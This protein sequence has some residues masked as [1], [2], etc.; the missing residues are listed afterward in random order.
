MRSTNVSLPSP[1]TLFTMKWIVCHSWV[2]LALVAIGCTGSP[3]AQFKDDPLYETYSKII[4]QY[5][6]H[7]LAG[8]NRIITNL[9]QAK[10]DGTIEANVFSA[11]KKK[12]VSRHVNLLTTKIKEFCQTDSTNY[13][14]PKAI[15]GFEKE[16]IMFRELS[17]SNIGKAESLVK[18]YKTACMAFGDIY[19]LTR[20]S[21]FSKSRY[22]KYTQL[23]KAYAY[24][25][26]PFRYNESLKEKITQYLNS[27]NQHKTSHENFDLLDDKD[28][29]DIDC[30]TE[31]DCY[32]SVNLYYSHK[33]KIRRVNVWLKQY[34]EYGMQFGTY[35]T[36]RLLKELKSLESVKGKSFVE[37]K[38]R[39]IAK[40]QAVLDTL[41]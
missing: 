40:L 38:E 17:V 4:D 16:V 21:P 29:E 24:D 25:K 28:F 22:D 11:L 2:L 1:F 6:K 35:D 7:N 27:L 26:D 13:R 34:G 23:L 9:D 39:L 20:Y 8:Y 14:D 32:F 41:Q 15:Q 37:E 18:D 33:C 3:E 31:G 12:L 36:E 30:T 10:N 5:E 19:N